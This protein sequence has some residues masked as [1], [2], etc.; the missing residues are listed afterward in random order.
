MPSVCAM[1]L[2]AWHFISIPAFRSQ[3]FT[4]L[5]DI[6]ARWARA[7]CV[8]PVAMRYARNSAPVILCPANPV[9]A[10]R[11]AFCTHWSKTLHPPF[12]TVARVPCTK[13]NT[14]HPSADCLG[15]AWPVACGVVCCPHHKMRL[16]R[17][18]KPVAKFALDNP[19]RFQCRRGRVQTF[20]FLSSL[21]EMSNT[22]AR[23]SGATDGL[24]H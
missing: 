20:G 3:Y 9:F 6:F 13:C 17:Y 16:R 8:K 11:P 15:C 14:S 19:G 7:F 23:I 12:L 18:D 2:T 1:R 5:Q 22:A 21:P 24:R 10:V 4:A